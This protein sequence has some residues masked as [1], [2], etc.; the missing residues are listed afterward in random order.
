LAAEELYAPVVDAVVAAVR[1]NAARTVVLVDGRSGSG[2][3]T[4][5]ALL[6]PALDA[7]LVR[8]DDLYPGW[9]G[10][11]AGSR[12]VAEQVLGR[13]SWT[14]WDWER[15]EPGETQLVDPERALVVEGSGA[16]SA[17]NR[18][19]ATIGVWVE[20]PADIRKA[21]ALTRDGDVYAREWDRWAAQE[22]RFEARERPRSMADI[23]VSEDPAG[24]LAVRRTG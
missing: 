4:L 11:A 3:T 7:Q 8:L 21:R 1:G 12:A 19:L 18:A 22:E 17:G 15:S 6:A 13:N 23:L 20:C 24:R 10:L 16:L 14:R 2:K 5:A 9:D